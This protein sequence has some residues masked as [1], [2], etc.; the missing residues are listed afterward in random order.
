[1]CIVVKQLLTVA[2]LAII[3]TAPVG[4]IAISLCGPVLLNKSLP[5]DHI[6]TDLPAANEQLLSKAAVE[7][8]CAEVCT[9][10]DDFQLAC[11]QLPH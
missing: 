7:T 11:D 5:D 6:S 1:M 9:V 8:D 10:V 4:A 3:V 2:V